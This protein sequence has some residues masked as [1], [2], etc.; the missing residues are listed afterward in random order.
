MLIYGF[1]NR[2][3][4]KGTEIYVSIGAAITNNIMDNMN[5]TILC[6]ID[7]KTVKNVFNHRDL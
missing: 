6:D 4:L 5:I 7:L 3:S 2:S 1:P